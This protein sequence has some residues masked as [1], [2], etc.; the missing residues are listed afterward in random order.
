MADVKIFRFSAIP[1]ENGGTMMIIY[2][3]NMKA[4]FTSAI[5]FLK[6]GA[7]LIVGIETF[8]LLK[9]STTFSKK[10]RK[11]FIN[12]AIIGRFN[13]DLFLGIS[14]INIFLKYVI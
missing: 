3:I 9:I 5:V 1:P 8:S 7:S 13:K 10:S 14:T 12:P 11:V 2:K 6:R 4:I